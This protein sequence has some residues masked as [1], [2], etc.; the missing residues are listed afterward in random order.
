MNKNIVFIINIKETDR[1]NRS[2]SYH[3][4]VLSWKAW[5]K[6]NNCDLFVLEESLFSKEIMNTIW[7][8]IYI[9]DLLES[10]N[11]EYNQILIV[12][13][14]TIIHP[15][16]PNIFD[17]TDEKFNVVRAYG[18]MD[19]VCRSYENYKKYVF[20]EITFS[21]FDYFNAGVIIINKKH[22]EL[23]KKLQNFY[24]DNRELLQ[25]LQSTYGTGTDQPVLNFF[26]RK[27]NV[28]FK[29]LPYE[30][31]MQDMARWEILDNN[32]TFTKIG[33]LYHFCAIEGGPNAVNYWMEKTYKYLYD[34]K[35]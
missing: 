18:S 25:K 27:E 3:Y 15:N 29:I 24:F 23:Y 7:Q 17:L 22:K 9:Y 30:W 20:P 28:D 35:K 4:S 26:L 8:K 21:P 16:A 10:N 31:N 34:T 33:W 32:F 19:W 1:P 14:D 12:D 11:I 2:Q 13:A 5:C 6:K